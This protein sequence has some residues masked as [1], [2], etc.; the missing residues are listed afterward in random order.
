MKAYSILLSAY[1]VLGAGSLFAAGQRLAPAPA[2][3][4][5]LALPASPLGSLSDYCSSVQGLQTLLSAPADVPDFN[6]SVPAEITG[7][8]DQVAALANVRRLCTSPC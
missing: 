1:L 5:S 4:L 3:G 6:V 7:S 2:P 8:P